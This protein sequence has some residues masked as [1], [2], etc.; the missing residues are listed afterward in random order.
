MAVKWLIGISF[1]IETILWFEIHFNY[2]TDKDF[3]QQNKKYKMKSSDKIAQ[4][5]NTFTT[6]LQR[7]RMISRFYLI[8]LMLMTGI[9]DRCWGWIWLSEFASKF[10][11][12]KKG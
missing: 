5:N 10:Y 8:G 11:V 3:D 7:E 4:Q 2:Y 9:G 12:T 1:L 6:T